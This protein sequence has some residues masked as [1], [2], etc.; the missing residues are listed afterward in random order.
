VHATP[1]ALAFDRPDTTTRHTACKERERFVPSCAC[2]SLAWWRCGQLRGS[3][4]Q[5][6]ST[7]CI[8]RRPHGATQAHSAHAHIRSAA[9]TRTRGQDH[10]SCPEHMG[11]FQLPPVVLSCCLDAQTV[12]VGPFA[13][14][15]CS[16]TGQYGV[17]RLAA[18]VCFTKGVR[19]QR[20]SPCTAAALLRH[21]PPCATPC[22]LHGTHAPRTPPHFPAGAAGGQRRRRGC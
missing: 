19:P 1:Q 20:L 15:S 4:H 17:K 11:P 18:T 10:A 14:S 16:R 8:G 7:A 3:A 13:E 21:A 5:H 22:C 9:H 12:K 6:A 2:G